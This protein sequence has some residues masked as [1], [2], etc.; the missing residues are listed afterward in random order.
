VAVQTGSRPAALITGGTSGTGLATARAHG[1]SVEWPLLGKLHDTPIAS[2]FCSW[3]ASFTSEQKMNVS[4]APK[5]ACTVITP[6]YN[7]LGC[8]YPQQNPIV[9][10]PILR[11]GI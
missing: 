7:S 11:R 4:I 1:T 5:D 3:E 8:F 9:K 6:K 2:G 10:N